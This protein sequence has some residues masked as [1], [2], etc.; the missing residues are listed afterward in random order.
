MSPVSLP[1]DQATRSPASSCQP[2]IP[3][4]GENTGHTADRTNGVLQACDVGHRAVVRRRLSG[5]PRFTE[6]L[7]VLLETGDERLVVR[8]EDGTVHAMTLDEVA[9]GKRVP[10]RP[11]KYSE[12]IALERVADRAWPAPTVE[13]LGQWRLRAADGW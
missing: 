13:E 7:G 4:G 3:T 2:N 8:A 1:N 5:W 6:V 9:A 10:P 12:I 11:A